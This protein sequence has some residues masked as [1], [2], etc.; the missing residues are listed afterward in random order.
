MNGNSLLKGS[1][2]IPLREIQAGHLGGA[3]VHLRDTGRG[4]DVV[5]RAAGAG[6]LQNSRTETFGHIWKVWQMA[7]LLV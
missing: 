2:A 4:L 3:Q 7:S 6:T 1:Q 5:A